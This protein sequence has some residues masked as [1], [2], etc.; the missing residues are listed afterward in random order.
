MAVMHISS[1]PISSEMIDPEMAASREDFVSMPKTNP[2]PDRTFVH[3]ELP[4]RGATCVS[5]PR[6]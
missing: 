1:D 2:R 5:E 6:P 3:R 4:F